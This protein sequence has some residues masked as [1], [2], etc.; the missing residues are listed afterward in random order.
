[1]LLGGQGGIFYIINKKSSPPGV[2]MAEEG[3]KSLHEIEMKLRK[4]SS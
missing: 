4:Y 1:M 3:T 2:E